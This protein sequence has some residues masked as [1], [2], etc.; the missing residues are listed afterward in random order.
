MAK[1]SKNGLPLGR[2][3]VSPKN[4]SSRWTPQ[5]DAYL[6]QALKEGKTATEVASRL[7]RTTVSVLSR[8]HLFFKDEGKFSKKRTRKSAVRTIQISQ[9]IPQ[10]TSIVEKAPFELFTLETGIP[11]PQKGK[12][13]NTVEMDRIRK[14]F[15]IMAPGQSFA[16]P[17]NLVH[18]AR[19]IANNEYGAYRIKVSATAKDQLFFRVFRML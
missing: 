4:K 16:I 19:K 14:L 8:K 11:M 15:D 10:P 3:S 9:P 1:F 5:E 18:I 12:K 2:P 6:K 13:P 7:G 17:K